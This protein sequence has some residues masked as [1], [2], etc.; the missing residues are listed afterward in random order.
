MGTIYEIKYDWW[1]VRQSKWI[2]ITSHIEFHFVLSISIW[3][4]AMKDNT[5]VFFLYIRSHALL[6]EPMM[7]LFLVLW[8]QVKFTDI[9]HWTQSNPRDMLT[10]HAHQNQTVYIVLISLTF[11]FS[12][13]HHLVRCCF[14]FLRE[15]LYANPNKMFMLLM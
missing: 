11:F 2:N 10:V 1:C 4:V 8:Q 5:F 6:N 9:I 13:L 3:F 14:Y 7:I 15:N 12:V